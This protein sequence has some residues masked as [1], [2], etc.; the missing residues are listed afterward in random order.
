M[1]VTITTGGWPEGTR[2]RSGRGTL[3]FENSQ[4]SANIAN[5]TIPKVLRRLLRKPGSLVDLGRK[6]GGLELL[7]AG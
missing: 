2:S 3:G 7:R 5:A 6:G 1:T 4:S